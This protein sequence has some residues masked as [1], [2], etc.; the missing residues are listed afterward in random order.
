MESVRIGIV[1]LGGMGSHHASYLLKGEVPHAKLTAVC[2]VAPDRL[3]WAKEHLGEGVAAYESADALFA[4]KVVDAIVIA[5]PHY[6]HPPIAV[7][8]FGHGLHVLTEKPAGVYT[9]QVREM[10]EA[11]ARSGKAFGIMFN[12]RTVPVYQK[13][14]ELMDSGELGTMKRSVWIITNWY[15][16]QSYYDSGG[17]RAT[18]AGEGG[19]VLINQCPHNLDLWQWICGMPRRLRAFV[20]FGKHHDIEVEDD[21]TAYVEYPNGATG[22]FV[23]TTG[24]APGTNRLEIA[25]DHGKLVLEGNS[26][27]FWRT[28][29]PVSRHIREYKGG[30]GEPECWKCEIPV[31]QG[32]GSH[33]EVTRKWVE[34]ILKGTPLTVHGAEGINSLQISNAMLLSAWTDAWVD[35]PVDEGLFYEKLQERVRAS[36][37]KKAGGKTMSVE[38]T[39]GT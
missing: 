16:A 33:A 5:T 28:R 3:A 13:L 18:W 7:Q 6:F 22:L 4:A 27:T 20:A 1:G 9:R 29:T 11:A 34:N 38:G 2:D 10:N 19:G 25:G 30:F 17:W 32:G 35:L 21:A 39:F 15:R 23:T 31:R 36:A 14:K 24:E 26:L 12:Q 8:A 37:A